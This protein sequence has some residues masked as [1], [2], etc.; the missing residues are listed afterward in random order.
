MGRRFGTI[1]S[2]L[3]ALC[4]GVSGLFP[5]DNPD[6]FGHLA[7]GRQIASL[8]HV[9]RLDTWSLLPGPPRA[10]VNYEWLSDLLYY[11][12]Y[13]RFGY[14]ALL[15]L[16][17]LALMVTSLAL[18]ACA[19]L[20]LG[21][22]AAQCTAL[23]VIASIPAARFRFTDRPHVLGLCLAALTLLALTQLARL[24]DAPGKRR[25]GLLAALFGLHVLWVNLHGSHLLG[26]AMTGCYLAFGPAPARRLFAAALL[27]QSV[28]CCISPYGPA[29]VID[30]VSHVLDPRYRALVSEWRPFRSSDSPW[31]A[32][33]PLLQAL[34]LLAVARALVRAQPDALPG[35]VLSAL[36]AVLCARSIRFTAEFVL[37]TAPF[38]GAGVAVVSR[39]W[40]A[41]RF[42]TS[43]MVGA[44]LL[45]LLVPLGA[46]ALPPHAG[47]GHGFTLR[48]RPAAAGAFLARARFAP[49]VLSS[50]EDGWFL[51]FAAP[52]AR[53]FMDGRVPFYGPE[54]TALAAA[55]ITD[56]A[57]FARIARAADINAVV[58]DFSDSRS[59]PVLTRLQE[60]PAFTLTVL[61]D[62]HATFVRAPLAQ[63]EGLRVLEPS[64]DPLPLLRALDSAP[65]ALHAD[66]QRLAG[67]PGSEGLRSWATALEVLAPLRRDRPQD[68]FRW[69][70]SATDFRRYERA[71]RL[72]ARAVEGAPDVPVVAAYH[73]LV[74]SMLCQLEPARAALSAAGPSASRETL[75]V[76]QEI[77]LR[78]GDISAVRA[79][80][81]A[82][83]RDPRATQDGWLAQLSQGLER[84]PD[85]P[86]GVQ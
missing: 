82:A 79:F 53:F 51:M 4:V 25:W 35:L 81:T 13:H 74:Q 73:A 21:A 46:S 50:M 19:A 28:A 32:L 64:Y 29:I 22:R 66:L 83:Q 6:T 55:A 42:A 77:A 68:G 14:D 86:P 23:V 71:A 76:Q 56:P 34:S 49:R 30:A 59:R 78:A 69:P 5:G 45:G 10:F 65:A 38:L 37:L 11:T 2:T 80:V 63:G 48:G 20:L 43:W 36:L 3:S 17:V 16:K 54:H 26:V 12:L 33:G 39:P 18:C 15:A 27:L 47:I 7:Q 8:G 40:P 70:H 24:R 57:T 84:A 72:I 31:Y 62:L 52:N 1:A 58:L 60:S 61:G 44:A 67:L 85:C 75:L 9:P 41:R